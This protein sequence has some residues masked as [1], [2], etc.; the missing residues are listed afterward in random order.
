M[1]HILL[2]QPITVLVQ[3][4]V[5]GPKGHKLRTGQIVELE[6]SP[7]TRILIKSGTVALVDPPSLDPEFLEKEGYELKVG[8]SYP[9]KE[10]AEN[11]I[12]EESIESTQFVGMQAEKTTIKAPYALT[13]SPEEKG[14]RQ[15]KI[16]DE[17]E[18]SSASEDPKEITGM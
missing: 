14:V 10:E 7:Y 8:Y 4:T 18:G 5:A 3:A 11:P 1:V 6:D 2:K 17:K 9:V 16:P 12:Q 13:T 15:E